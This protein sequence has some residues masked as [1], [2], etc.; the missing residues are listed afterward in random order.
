MNLKPLIE[1][2]ALLLASSVFAV[3]LACWIV[4]RG[5]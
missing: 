3:A 2:I 1:L 5:A 4:V